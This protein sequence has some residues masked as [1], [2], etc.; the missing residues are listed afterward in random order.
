MSRPVFCL[1]AFVTSCTYCAKKNVVP[2]AK[3]DPPIQ[4]EEAT[5]VILMLDA[6]T[7][8]EERPPDLRRSPVL[9]CISPLESLEDEGSV[10]VVDT[11]RIGL[12]SIGVG[13]S[14]SDLPPRDMQ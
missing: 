4:S 7:N 8:T 1:I 2:E 5:S 12:F 3:L 11:L 14:T 13:T 9:V 10:C 6:T